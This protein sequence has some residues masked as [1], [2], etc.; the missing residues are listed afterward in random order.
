MELDSLNTKPLRILIS[1]DDGV[2][3]QGIH[4]LADELRSIA[5]VIIVAPD[6]N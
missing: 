4:A 5:E 2:H 1:N 3:A 6:R